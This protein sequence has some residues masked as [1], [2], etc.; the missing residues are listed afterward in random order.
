MGEWRQASIAGE[1]NLRVE[2]EV[3]IRITTVDPE[4]DRATGETFYRCVEE[5]TADLSQ[6]GAF[7]RSWE[8]LVAGRRVV[9]EIEL[10][11][12]QI[13]ELR[14]RVAWTQRKVQSLEATSRPI[15]RPGYGLEF[16]PSCR[17]AITRIESHLATTPNPSA[18]ALSQTQTSVEAKAESPNQPEASQTAKASRSERL[19][20]PR[21]TTSRSDANI[22]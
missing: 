12:N 18:F 20:P 1:R 7:V 22:V 15:E 19:D 5:T 14:A 8:P 9:V 4:T 11:G 21:R 17:S 6:G 10:P 13:L 3:P 2:T 16:D